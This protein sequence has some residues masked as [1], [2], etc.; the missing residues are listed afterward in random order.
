[1]FE[2]I[3]KI[4]FDTFSTLWYFFLRFDMSSFIVAK[5]FLSYDANNFSLLLLLFNRK[6]NRKKLS[7]QQAETVEQKSLMSDKKYSFACKFFIF[8]E[9]CNC[10]WT[11]YV[12]WNVVTL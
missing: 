10:E 1:M 11:L 4:R 12:L 7:T 5:Y 3:I 6:K 9:G 8:N 2:F